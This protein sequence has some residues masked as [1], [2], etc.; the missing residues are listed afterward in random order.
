[1]SSPL[2]FLGMPHI[3]L[4]QNNKIQISFLHPNVGAAARLLLCGQPERHG[5]R[6]SD[7]QTPSIWHTSHCSAAEYLLLCP[8][9]NA[10]A[11]A[12]L[13]FYG[14]LA[15]L[16]LQQNTVLSCL[17]PN[18]GAAAR[19]LLHGQPERH[20]IRV[21]DLPRHSEPI[22]RPSHVSPVAHEEQAW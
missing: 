20:A 8:H 12:R 10:G 21:S 17:H 19:L 16:T 13:L 7:V 5:I 11:A 4:Q 22:Q 2:W 18:A 14:Y 9:H 1:M 6:V 15:C 3:A